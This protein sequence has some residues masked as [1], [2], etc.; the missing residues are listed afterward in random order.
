MAAT[1]GRL[2][3]GPRL[4]QLSCRR[5]RNEARVTPASETARGSPAL[6]GVRHSSERRRA[7]QFTRTLLTLKLKRVGK[8][9]QRKREGKRSQSS[10]N[11]SLKTYG[12]QVY[13]SELILQKKFP[14]L[15]LHNTKEADAGRG[16]A[17]TVRSPH[18]A[19]AAPRHAFPEGW[20]GT[21]RHSDP[22]SRACRLPNG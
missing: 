19:G 11:W 4:G 10:K 6:G 20:E 3:P 16:H 22:P 21:S 15:L 9:L 14:G 1:R 5:H 2:Q 12:S 17:V 8:S 18:P 7:P 13:P